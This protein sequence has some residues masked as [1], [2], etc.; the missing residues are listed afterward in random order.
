MA[1]YPF[2]VEIYF[3]DFVALLEGRAQ[4]WDVIGG[5]YQGWFIGDALDSPVYA[6]MDVYGEHRRPDLAERCYRFSL[7]NLTS[8]LKVES[9]RAT[10]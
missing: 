7:D 5:S 1:T 6:L 10:R 3:Q 4:I 2:G 8:S 9:A